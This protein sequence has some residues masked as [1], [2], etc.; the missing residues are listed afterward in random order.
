[1]STTAIP[2]RLEI[3]A[4]HE[5]VGVVELAPRWGPPIWPAESPTDGHKSQEVVEPGWMMVAIAYGRKV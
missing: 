3:R 1:M 4:L 2:A 5:H